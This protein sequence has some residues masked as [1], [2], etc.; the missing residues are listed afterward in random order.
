MLLI[1]SPARYRIIGRTEVVGD[2][3][4][5]YFNNTRRVNRVCTDKDIRTKISLHRML[6]IGRLE[7]GLSLHSG[8]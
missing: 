7:P 4:S 3:I 2:L 8:L 6:D 1:A 5:E